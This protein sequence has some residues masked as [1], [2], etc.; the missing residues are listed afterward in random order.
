[1][2]SSNFINGK[3]LNIEAAIAII[4]SV[5]YIFF[6]F[7]LFINDIA[8]FEKNFNLITG[9]VILIGSL[10]I[11]LSGVYYFTSKRYV[12]QVYILF[13]G[14]IILFISEIFREVNFG[15]QVDFY[16]FIFY[17][18]PLLL[19]GLIYL[20]FKNKLNVNNNIPQISNQQNNQTPSPKNEIERSLINKTD[21]TFAG[22]PSKDIYE[23]AI[24]EGFS[25]YEAYKLKEDR[26]EKLMK[27]MKVSTKMS[28][29]DF[30]QYLGINDK[31]SFLEWLADLPEGSPIYLEENTVVFK[32][33]EYSDKDITKDIDNLLQSF[34][35]SGREKI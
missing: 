7:L 3:L 6:D 13:F 34:N 32:S 14:T 25:T 4:F 24:S 26:K 15:Q 2:S 9:I 29:D 19:I 8:Y 1:M 31:L 33:R 30:M 23:K 27:I 22:F 10:I 21:S 28:K 35:K 11:F 5:F 17:S 16:I 18:I 20:I 12:Q